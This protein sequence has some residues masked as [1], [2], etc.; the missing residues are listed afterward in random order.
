MLCVKTRGGGGRVHIDWLRRLGLQEKSGGKKR[1]VLDEAGG[2]GHSVPQFMCG[3]WPIIRMARPRDAHASE[4]IK[5]F[6][7]GIFWTIG[8]RFSIEIR[9]GRCA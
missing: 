1:C 8:G 2:Q 4:V 7:N 9:F 6:V 5:V 3:V